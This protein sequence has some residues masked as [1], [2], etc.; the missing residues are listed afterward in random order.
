MNI[1]YI[2]HYAGSKELGMEFRPYYMGT[3]WKKMGHQVFVLASSFTHLRVRQPKVE[4]NLTNEKIDGLDFIWLKGIKYKG[5]GIGRF[6]NI[7]QFL[8]GIWWFRKKILNRCRPNVII[9]SSTYPMDIWAAKYLAKLCGAQLVFELHDVWPQ[10]LTEVAGL[11]EWHP[12]VILA[13]AAERTC[14]RDA[15]R[16]ISLLPSIHGHVTKMGFDLNRLAIVPNGIVTEDWASNVSNMLPETLLRLISEFKHK[17]HTIVCY[18]GAHGVPNALD[19]LLKA[20]DL[21]RDKPVSFLLV[22]EGNHKLNLHSEIKQMNLHNVVMHKGI[23]KVLIPELLSSIDIGFIGAKKTPIY[24]HGISSNKIVDYMM[25]GVPIICAINA[26]NDPVSEA[27]CGLSIPPND[28]KALATAIMDI[29]LLGKEGRLKLGEYGRR[30][31]VSNY[32]YE[33]LANRFL[34]ALK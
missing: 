22:G 18:I 20:A 15:D 11:P 27:K 33:V 23:S 24:S 14:Y 31:A 26:G 8:I 29:M 6:I 3:H 16:I 17:N 5:N 34:E 4:R 9:A 30:Y 13:G 2:N 25:A 28:H 32:S 1:L 7:C 10:S 21:L 12:L 19:N